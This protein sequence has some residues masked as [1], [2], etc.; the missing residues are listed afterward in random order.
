MKEI[1]QSLRNTVRILRYLTPTEFGFS[2]KEVGGES[3]PSPQLIRKRAEQ[4]AQK[5]FNAPYIS[6][7]GPNNSI[8][9]SKNKLLM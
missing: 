5:S 6:R 2:E 7:L 3:E 8:I 1:L 4:S 9:I